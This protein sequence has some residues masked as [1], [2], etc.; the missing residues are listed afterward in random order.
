MNR[1]K[2]INQATSYTTKLLRNRF[3][4]G[5]E[6]VSIYL[7]EQCIVLHLKNFLSPVEKFLLSQEKEQAFRYTRE[8]IMK[9]MLPEL[10]NFLTQQL[11]LKV[12]D[13]YYDWG[14]YNA[15]GVIV[16]LLDYDLYSQSEDYKGKEQLH[17]YIMKATT[18]LQKPPTWIDS[19]WINSKTL[20]ILRKGTT[21]LLEKE[22]IS[23]G[24][25]HMLR[26]TK[27]KIEKALLEQETNLEPLFNKKI[28]D[29]YVDWSFEN[30]HSM[31]MYTFE[32]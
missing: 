20:F 22:L 9:S 14:M 5:P 12:V 27:G 1:K 23:M 16:G 28:A 24:Y 4:K 30:D 13:L 26:M 29:L 25:E 18:E 31:I 11:D 17:E 7:C 15:S 32:E 2:I 10:R 19:W 3:G 6:A 8:L 21:I